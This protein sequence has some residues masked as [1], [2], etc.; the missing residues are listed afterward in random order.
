MPATAR[1]FSSSLLI[2]LVEI[3]NVL[4]T[5]LSVFCMD[6]TA[7]LFLT[8]R[9]EAMILRKRCSSNKMCFQLSIFHYR[10]NQD[11]ICK[12]DPSLHVCSAP[13]RLLIRYNS[14][15][16]HAKSVSFN[17]SQHLISRCAYAQHLIYICCEHMIVLYIFLP[18]SHDVHNML[19]I[20]V[21]I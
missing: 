16:V 6:C 18:R 7:S 4:S 3:L 19:S 9:R 17:T 11:C 14:Q 21:I 5:L 15:D 13:K 12:H 1:L 8:Q 2:C 10:T 20:V